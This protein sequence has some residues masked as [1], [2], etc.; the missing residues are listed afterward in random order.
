[1]V[2]RKPLERRDAIDDELHLRTNPAPDASHRYQANVG[3][4]KIVRV[5][6]FVVGVDRLYLFGKK[7]QRRT[8][9]HRD[10]AD[11]DPD[12]IGCHSLAQR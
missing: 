6:N 7:P 4:N 12:S 8:Q 3:I 2:E 5:D 11:R 1:M 9:A 10:R